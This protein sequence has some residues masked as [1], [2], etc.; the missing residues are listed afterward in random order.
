MHVLHHACAARP[1]PLVACT[2]SVHLGTCCRPTTGTH[3]DNTQSFAAAH[4]GSMKQLVGAGGH[5]TQMTNA[6]RGGRVCRPRVVVHLLHARAC[7]VR[8]NACQAGQQLGSQAERSQH[9]VVPRIT[10]APIT[11][12]PGHRCGNTAGAT[13]TRVQPPSSPMGP[14]RLSAQLWAAGTD[15]FFAV[16]SNVASSVLARRRHQRHVGLD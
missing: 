4:V 12:Q 6:A 2:T 15:E 9:V 7:S 8:S 11:Y 16:Q 5:I 10:A 13:K 1:T 3:P 14:R